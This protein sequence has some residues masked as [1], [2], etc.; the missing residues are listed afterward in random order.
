M[1]L[2]R[3]HGLFFRSLDL[4]KSPFLL[5][6]LLVNYHLGVG[7]LVENRTNGLIK[8]I[9]FGSLMKRCWV[10]GLGWVG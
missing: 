8:S 3:L 10:F 1:L 2:L 7:G 5:F 6:D 9:Q 4:R